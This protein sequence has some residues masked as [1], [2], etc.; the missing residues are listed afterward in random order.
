MLKKT[1]SLSRRALKNTVRGSQS[2][3][4]ISD[5]YITVYVVCRI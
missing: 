3:S 2:L 4:N 5:A 1:L